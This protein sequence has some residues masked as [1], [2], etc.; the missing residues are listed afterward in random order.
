MNIPVNFY[1][2]FSVPYISGLPSWSLYCLHGDLK[3]NVECTSIGK[4]W[5]CEKGMLAF[6]GVWG[7]TIERNDLILVMCWGIYWW[8][9]SRRWQAAGALMKA[10]F[11]DLQRFRAHSSIGFR[12][13]EVHRRGK[14][15]LEYV[16]WDSI[17]VLKIPCKVWPWNDY[18]H[19]STSSLGQLGCA[20]GH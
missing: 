4:W 5:Y 1:R 12:C 17:K 19:F 2:G 18:G 20:S 8:Q 11:Q 7:R 16:F 6:I 14:S 13:L 10:S 15:I 3:W 9:F